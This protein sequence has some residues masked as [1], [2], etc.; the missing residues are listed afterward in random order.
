VHHAPSVRVAVLLVVV[1]ALAAC[2]SPGQ[3]AAQAACDAYADTSATTT[4]EGDDIRAQAE[5]D[6]DRA[7]EAD[8]TWTALK[9]D[10]RDVHERLDAMAATQS[11]GGEVSSGDMDAYFA[12]DERVRADCAS[13]GNDIG[14]LRP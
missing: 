12:A 6:A 2:R 7:A 11:T 5:A 8:S 4:A 3:D 1:L 9:R 10:I 14:P 13:A